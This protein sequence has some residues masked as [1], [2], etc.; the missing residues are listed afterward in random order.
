M[1]HFGCLIHNQLSK[2]FSAGHGHQSTWDYILCTSEKQTLLSQYTVYVNR[3]PQS[4]LWP[5]SPLRHERWRNST[6]DGANEWT[7]NPGGKKGWLI[8]YRDKYTIQ[9][10]N[11]TRWVFLTRWTRSALT[12]TLILWKTICVFPT[13]LLHV[14]FLTYDSAHS[15]KRWS[16]NLSYV[17]FRYQ[18]HLGLIPNSLKST[19]ILPLTLGILE[20]NQKAFF[21]L[22]SWFTVVLGFTLYLSYFGFL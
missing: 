19:K 7:E 11:F 8:L 20:Q 22:S 6:A 3:P 13:F 12:S 2:Y 16:T 10:A 21:T 14:L 1:S 17:W 15:P 18:G 9:E 5:L 4:P